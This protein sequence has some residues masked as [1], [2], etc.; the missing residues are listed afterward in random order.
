MDFLFL[1]TDDSLASAS[2][3]L[4]LR[5]GILFL[6]DAGYCHGVAIR[7]AASAIAT[8]RQYAFAGAAI[9]AISIRPNTPRLLFWGMRMSNPIG[10]TVF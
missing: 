1:N 7:L 3:H 8:R 5:D 4:R 10:K 2:R 9:G 6:G